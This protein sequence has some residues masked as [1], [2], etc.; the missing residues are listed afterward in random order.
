MAF[1]WRFVLSE[2]SLSCHTWYMTRDLG[3]HSFV[4]GTAALSHLVRQARSSGGPILTQVS[5]ISLLHP[6]KSLKIY[7]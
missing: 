1:A 3:L 4:R 2:G 7:I 5:F 6:Y